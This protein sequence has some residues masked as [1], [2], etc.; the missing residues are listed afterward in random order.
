M[1]LEH[2]ILSILNHEALTGY[3]LKKRIDAS[4]GHFW[5]TTQSHIYKALR[6]LESDNMVSMREVLQQNRPNRKVYSITSQ[7]QHELKQWLG[8]PM[9]CDP[10]REA[11]LMQVFFSYPLENQQII[12]L[13]EERIQHMKA[14]LNAYAEQPRPTK[15]MDAIEG[16]NE[17]VH[18]LWALTFDYGKAY[19]EF[20]IDW[21][22]KALDR[23]LNLPQ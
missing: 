18:D 15:E 9:E 6:K 11:W 2:A 22:Q 17:R 16:S 4:I 12:S 10:V 3:D 7:G 19:L 5:S 8:K 21:H 23:I 13:F 14:Q 1:P 20:Q